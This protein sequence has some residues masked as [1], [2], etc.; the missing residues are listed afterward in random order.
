M[1]CGSMYP[2][3]DKYVNLNVLNTFKKFKFKTG[4]SDH[5]MGYDAAMCASALGANFFE[6][7]FTL[8]KKSKDQ[9]TFSLQNQKSLKLM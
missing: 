6:K 8:N 5:T 3:P 7:H 2:L 1:Q 9:I 4:F